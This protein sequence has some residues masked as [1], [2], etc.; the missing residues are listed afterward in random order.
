MYWKSNR[1]CR[2]QSS[3][4]AYDSVAYDIVKTTL[5]E[6]QAGRKHSEVVRTSIVVGSFFHSCLRLRQSCIFPWII[7]D[8][9]IS[10]IGRKW[11][12]SESSDSDFVELLTPLVTPSFDFHDT[13]FFI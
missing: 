11:K 12:R 10:G 6:S 3:D 2:K 1:R 5:S 7:S 13:L 9:V 8:G 4:S